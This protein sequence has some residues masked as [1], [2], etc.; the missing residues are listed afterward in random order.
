MWQPVEHGACIIIDDPLLKPRYG[1][2]SF[3]KLLQQMKT[4]NFTTDIS[5]IPWNRWRTSKKQAAFFSRESDHFSV[6]IH[7]CDHIAAEFGDKNTDNLS[8]KASLAQS[9]MMA[10]QKRTGIVYEP[11]M[12]FP[13]GVFSESCPEILKKTGYLAAVNTEIVPMG[14]PKESTRLR[15]VWDVA[16]TRY[17]SFPIFTRRYAHHGI[18]NFAFDLLLGKP[19]LIVAHHE[20]FKNDGEAVIDLVQKLKSL[21]CNLKWRP[22]GEVLRRS[23]RYRINDSGV[24]EYWMYANEL[25]VENDRDKPVEIT[26]RKR[27][28]DFGLIDSIESGQKS[29]EWKA[30]DEYIEFSAASLVEKN[31]YLRSIIKIYPKQNR[32]AA[33]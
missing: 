22:L 15:D 7:G 4:H 27:E 8:A 5:F 16:I 29:L 19:C 6:S 20:F 12:V 13:Q 10:H 31:G 28:N 3:K 30:S 33:A 25:W 21:K 9:R 24:K 18:E 2:C 1:C 11:I 32:F 14:N 23:C 26:V 17:G